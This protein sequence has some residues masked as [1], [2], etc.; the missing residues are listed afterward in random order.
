MNEF[1]VCLMGAMT[2]NECF[3]IFSL[4]SSSIDPS[5]KTENTSIQ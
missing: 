2:R 4:Q 5:N 3:S 1:D